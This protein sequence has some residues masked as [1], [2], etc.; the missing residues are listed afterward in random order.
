MAI[1][2]SGNRM[3]CFEAHTKFCA[4]ISRADWTTP[5][6]DDKYDHFALKSRQVNKAIEEAR[7]IQIPY[8]WDLIGV[9]NV[10]SGD[11]VS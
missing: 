5:G 4:I 2:M 6:L 3:I 8:G 11:W 1:L 10:D 9:R 7:L